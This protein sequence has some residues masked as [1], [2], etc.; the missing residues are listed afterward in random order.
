MSKE[1]SPVA[2]LPKVCQACDTRMMEDLF[3]EHS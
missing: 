3:D 1:Q 2:W